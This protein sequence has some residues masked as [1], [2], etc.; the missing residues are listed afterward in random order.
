MSVKVSFIGRLG[1]D[2]EIQT[3]QSTNAQFIKFNVGTSESIK[4]GESATIWFSVSADYNR[5]KNYFPYLKKGV[6]I[7]VIGN[8][9]CGIYTNNQGTNCIAR[10]VYV[11]SIEFIH[12]KGSSANSNNNNQQMAN[13]SAGE[14]IV[15]AQ[16][17]D[18]SVMPEEVPQYNTPSVEVQEAASLNIPVSNDDLPF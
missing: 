11:D 10:N 13:G 2:A 1:S 5:F 16:V 15:N 14:S 12:T 4:K 17:K 3:T 8:E 18:Y 7:Q 9:K 6:F